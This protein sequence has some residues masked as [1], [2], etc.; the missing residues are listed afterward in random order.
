L[1]QQSLQ[2]TAPTTIAQFAYHVSLLQSKT[3]KQRKESLAYLTTIISS[4]PDGTLLPEPVATLLPKLVRL[5]TDDHPGVRQQLMKLLK[6]LPPSEVAS[7]VQQLML[8]T[9]LTMT[10][11]KADLRLFSLEIVEWL[12]EIAPEEVVSCRGGWTKMLAC[13][14]GLLG[15]ANSATSGNGGWIVVTP[16]TGKTG[17][18]EKTQVKQMNV[19]ASFIKAGT[20]T[21]EAQDAPATTTFPYSHVQQHLLPQRSN[22]FAHLNLFGVKRDD[23]EMMFEDREDRQRILVQRHVPVLFK[24]VDEVRKQGGELGRA[25][26]TLGNAIAEC[27]ASYVDET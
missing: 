10:H 27:V 15:W 25:G 6:I 7:H 8:H 12:L 9:Q 13:F 1:K 4:L 11:M 20:G 2:E 16:I 24:K 18:D 5:I 26:A 19:F 21:P 14:M 22:A 17:T 23:E 3:D